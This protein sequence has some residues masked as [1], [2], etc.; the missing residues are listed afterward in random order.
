[1]MEKK[2]DKNTALAKISAMISKYYENLGRT[3]IEDTEE[4]KQE[5]IEKIDALLNKT[6]IPTKNLIIE[7]LGLDD[8][9]KE[10]LKDKW[11]T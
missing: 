3:I 1:M 5:L 10:E 2:L 6:D 7:K 9:I 4:T 11:K 8:E